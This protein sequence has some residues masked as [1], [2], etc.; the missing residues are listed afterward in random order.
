MSASGDD[1]TV[2][3]QSWEQ[4]FT[5]NP[6][7]ENFVETENKIRKFVNCQTEK[8]KPICLVTSGS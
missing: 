8:R 4:F 3:G 6:A 1:N 5:T 7:P 2:T